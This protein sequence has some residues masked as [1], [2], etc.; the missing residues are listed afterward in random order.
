[1]KEQSVRGLRL[2]PWQPNDT[3][4]RPGDV[5]KTSEDSAY[6]HQIH[7]VDGIVIG[8]GDA[9]ISIWR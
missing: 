7:S 1:M 4:T 5:Y 3:M 6:P 9:E 2:L 8:Q